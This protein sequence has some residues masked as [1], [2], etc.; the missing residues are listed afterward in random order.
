[1][2]EIIDTPKSAD[3][4]RQKIKYTSQDTGANWQRVAWGFLKL[5]GANKCLNTEKKI[6]LQLFYSQTKYKNQSNESMVPEIY[7][8]YKNG[9]RIKYPTS[10]H[11]TVKSILPP[12]SFEPGIRSLYALNQQ[13]SGVEVVWPE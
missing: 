8:I 2:Y 13:N 9:P 12:S 3:F 11:V 10:L 6:R 1:M 4:T 5:V 7:N